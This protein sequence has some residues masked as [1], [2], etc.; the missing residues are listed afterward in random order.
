MLV[1]FVSCQ[2]SFSVKSNSSKC[3]GAIGKQWTQF[4]KTQMK[5][6]HMKSETYSPSDTVNSSKTN[7][8]RASIKDI[9]NTT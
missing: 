6:Y 3:E 7:D 2:F 8:V 5:A 1:T 4:K 9:I